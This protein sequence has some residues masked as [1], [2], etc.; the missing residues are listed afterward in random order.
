MTGAMCPTE[1]VEQV[2]LFRWAEWQA[3]KYPV[4]E[5]L[6]HVPNGGKRGKAEAGRSHH[7]LF[8]RAIQPDL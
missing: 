4:L 3:C 1:D 8:G 5:M 2:Q 6:Y 7:G